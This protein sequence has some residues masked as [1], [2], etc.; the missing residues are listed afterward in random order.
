MAGGDSDNK[1]TLEN[2]AAMLE[3]DTFDDEDACEGGVDVDSVLDPL[4]QEQSF[5]V[6]YKG[7]VCSVGLGNLDLGNMVNG[8]DN[9]SLEDKSFDFTFC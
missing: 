8:F 7:S 6:S 9:D 5:T 4:I 2:L 3:V 1:A